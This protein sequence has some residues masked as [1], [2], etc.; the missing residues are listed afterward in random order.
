MLLS[1][2]R[3]VTVALK[4]HK[5]RVVGSIP[6]SAP[7]WGISSVGRASPLQGGCQEFESPILHGNFCFPYSPIAQL[8]E[9]GAVNSGVVRSSRTGGV[10]WVGNIRFIHKFR[11]HHI[12]NKPSAW[13][14]EGTFGVLAPVVER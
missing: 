1:L 2:R 11:D 12:R 14:A 9:H 6:T 3:S 8:A 4:S 7:N 10:E 5:L 13:Y